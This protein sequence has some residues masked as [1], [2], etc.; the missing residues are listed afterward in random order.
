VKR[1]IH[2]GIILGIILSGLVFMNGITEAGGTRWHVIL[3]R[4]QDTVAVDT[5][6][7][8]YNKDANTLSYWTQTRSL[9]RA[10]TYMETRDFYVLNFKDRTTTLKRVLTYMGDSIEDTEGKGRDVI[11]PVLPDSIENSVV[12]Y[13][14]RTMNTPKVF[15]TPVGQWKW[16]L[17]T[18]KYTCTISP[19]AFVDDSGY[20]NVYIRKSYLSGLQNYDLY[21]F[22]FSHDRIIEKDF[23]GNVSYKDIIPES[24]DEK[25]YKAA[26]ELYIKKQ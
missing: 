13:A 14:H 15:P 5:E 8:E 25:I 18:D 26:Y 12:E 24:I 10:G 20:Y 17:S 2:L 19:D 3:T 6:T 1:A 4:G 7:I 21:R 23:L 22:D 9:T 11:S 16:V